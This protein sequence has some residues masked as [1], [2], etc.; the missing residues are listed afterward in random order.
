M[1]FEVDN[2]NDFIHD[3]VPG[4]HNSRILRISSDDYCTE[5]ACRLI[6]KSGKALVKIFLPLK[7]SCQVY[8][9]RLEQIMCS[10]FVFELSSELDLI[11]LQTSHCKLRAIFCF[12]FV[13]V[14]Q[15]MHSAIDNVSIN[16]VFPLHNPPERQEWTVDKYQGLTREQSVALSK[17]IESSEG[18][19]VLLLG[20]FGSGKTRTIAHAIIQLYEDMKRR[21][22]FD[23]RILICTHSNSAA[24][25]Y[26]EDFIDPYL[27]KE[28]FTH[29]VL[30]RVNWEL[31]YTASVSAT[32]LKYCEV[33]NGKFVQPRKEDIEKHTIVISTL[34]TA[35][36]L[37]EIGVEK[38][39][40]THIFIDE[41]AQAMEVE[42]L[43]P[44]VLTGEKTKVI[45]AGD[46]L[47]VSCFSRIE[48]LVF[49]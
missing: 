3:P 14:F 24:D 17:M 26:I 19:P 42:A 1:S 10:E 43:I 8:E 38:G 29:P 11:L 4:L 39:F 36:V 37:H 5:Q 35:N 16:H 28:N 15:Y 30:I 9:V 13:D 48:Q 40:F 41:A 33:R 44:L 25:H 7:S 45:L 32:V 31:R 34:V 6:G 21:R 46:H 12:R 49:L 18:P 27:V 22:N 47:Q 2:I 23:K 20:P